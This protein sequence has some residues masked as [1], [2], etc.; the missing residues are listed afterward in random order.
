M[1]KSIKVLTESRYG[2]LIAEFLK[3]NTLY[4]VHYAELDSILKYRDNG[5]KGAVLLI[6]VTLPYFID[7]L[8][9]R[10]R[11]ESFFSAGVFNCEEGSALCIYAVRCGVRGFFYRKEEPKE[12]V[13]GMEL[14]VGGKIRAPRSLLFKA[15]SKRE[16]E[17]Y[18][19]LLERKLTT[20]EV[21]VFML[22]HDGLSNKGIGE[23]LFISE[24]TVKRHVTNIFRKLGI[25]SREEIKEWDYKDIVEHFS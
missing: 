5:N 22:V 18:R 4:N 2:T 8:E 12:I 6:D 13:K 19:G 9:E 7:L 10:S 23:R 15:A 24:Y 21:R 20:Q 3:T 11:I 1:V 14:L 16:G 17:L 25:G